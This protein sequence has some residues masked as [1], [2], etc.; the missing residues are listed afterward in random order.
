M[1]KA[2][3]VKEIINGIEFIKEIQEVQFYDSRGEEFYWWLPEEFEK[4]QIGD[5]SFWSIDLGWT[6]SEEKQF[7]MSA[8]KRVSEEEF[9]RLMKLRAFQ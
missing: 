1:E 4:N 2:K 3:I 8:S 9:W 6:N 5:F 7:W